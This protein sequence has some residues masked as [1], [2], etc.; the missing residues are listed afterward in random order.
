[1]IYTALLVV[2]NGWEGG[3]RLGRRIIVRSGNLLAVATPSPPPFRALLIMTLPFP[4]NI[5]LL[6]LNLNIGLKILIQRERTGDDYA[7][8]IVVNEGCMETLD[9]E[10]LRLLGVQLWEGVDITGDSANGQLI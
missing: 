9:M 8:N 4:L 5:A 10:T 6:R 2:T 7:R 3:R 1:M